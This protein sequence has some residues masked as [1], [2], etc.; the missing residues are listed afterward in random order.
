MQSNKI[1]NILLYAAVAVFLFGTGYK[2][3]GYNS[4]NGESR[5]E[6]NF[7]NT[8][9]S[10]VNDKNVDFSLF[11]DTWNKLEEKYV[12]KKKLDK[13]KMYYGAIKGM[14]ASVEDP[15]TFFLTPEEN[16][17]TKEELGGRFEGIGAQL[18]LKENRIVIVAP[19]KDSPAE[20][21]G[22]MAGDVISGVNGKSTK[23]WTLAQGVSKIRGPKN[24]SVKLTIERG[25]NKKDYTIMRDEVKIPTIEVTY[26]SNVAV[27][28]I[29]QFG[30]Q[31]NNE[32]DKAIS[33]ISSKWKNKEITGMVLDLRDNPGGFLD[34]AVYIASEFIPKGKLVVKQ[35]STIAS[36]TRDYTVY[37]EGK[38]LDIP[39]VV[40][41]NEGS[42]SASEIVAGC[43][44]DYDR[45]TLVGQKSFGK[46]SVQEA[47]DLKDNAGL[48]VTIAKWILPNG[49]WI[50]GKGIEPKI[51]VQNSAPAEGSTE[52]PADDQLE[53]AIEAVVK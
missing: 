47:I 35:E 52:K 26:K 38:L 49:D 42:A 29:N 31:T 9:A 6:T 11:W 10:T 28:K 19:L 23:G 2:L 15:Y 34:S 50:N 46:G 32:W 25:S 44:R 20:K 41:I 48:H 7:L 1:T 12:D 37:R 22:L 3:G 53:K 45:T 43:L 18:G 24:T 14:T 4:V 40:M 5:S 30:E 17:Q 51:K 13:K 36:E 21:A 27:L 39:I 16:K 8:N 33:E